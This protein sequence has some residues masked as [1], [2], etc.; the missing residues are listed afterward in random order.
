M[1]TRAGVAL[2][3]SSLDKP[4]LDFIGR[5]DKALYSAKQEGRNRVKEAET[6]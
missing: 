3:S 2:Y 5:E 6:L 1:K 4:S